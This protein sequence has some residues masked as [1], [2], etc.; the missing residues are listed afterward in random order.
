MVAWW[1]AGYS[2]GRLRGFVVRVE[3]IA[4]FGKE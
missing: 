2:E 3:G 1:T 4:R